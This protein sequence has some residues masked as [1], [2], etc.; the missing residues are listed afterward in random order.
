LIP[1]FLLTTVDTSNPAA[2]LQ[3]GLAD[4]VEQHGRCRLRLGTH[5]LGK[6]SGRPMR[7]RLEM[8]ADT[9][10]FPDGSQRPIAATAVEA[11][12]LGAEIRPGLAAEFNPPP[13]WAQTVPYVSE[14]ATGFLGILSSRAQERLALGTS[15]LT[16]QPSVPGELQ[17][18]ASQAGSQAVTDFTRARLKEIEDRYAAYYLIPAGTACWLQLDSD[19]T[20]PTP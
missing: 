20:A 14:L 2:V 10:L 5:L 3:F 12:D 9:V 4:D 16:L 7:G 6:L 11:D 1:V 17:G 18:S 8:T 19:F 13:V 15:G